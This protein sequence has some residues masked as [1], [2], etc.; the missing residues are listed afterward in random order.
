M[1][2]L[3]V[4]AYYEGSFFFQFKYGRKLITCKNLN[5]FFLFPERF[6][7]ATTQKPVVAST[8]IA[9]YARMAKD[10]NTRPLYNVDLL[11]DDV[12]INNGR[13]YHA[14]TGYFIAPETGVYVFTWTTR[15][16]GDCLHSTSLMVNGTGI[17]YLPL[18]SAF[19][20][21]DYLATGVVVERINAGDHV[22]VFITGISK[23]CNLGRSFIE[24]GSSFGGWKIA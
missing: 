19:H 3:P 22:H 11:Y 20:E 21:E 4:V 7:P 17:G 23:P 10:I 2:R 16:R 13:G 9:F 18:Y 12:H 8:I 15:E 14:T 1:H 5:I 24:Q 6:Y